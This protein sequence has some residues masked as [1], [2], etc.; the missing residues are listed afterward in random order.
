[1]MN[2]KG[3]T[4]TWTEPGNTTPL[5]SN[6]NKQIMSA[7]DRDNVLGD[8]DLGSYLNKI[9]DPNYVDPA[10]TKRVGNN[11]LDKDSFL[12]LFLA[13]L[14]NQDPMSPLESHE[15][16]AQLAQF[17]S[18]EK[19]GAID[20]GIKDL[21][22]A[23]N[24]AKSFDS[25]AMIGRHIEGDSSKI[26][27]TDTKEAHDIRFNL[28]GDAVKATL[29]VKN[30]QGAEIRKMEVSG[31]KKGD[32][33]V[34]WDGNLENGAPAPVGDYTVAISANSSSGQKI[35]AETAFRGQVTGV[36]FTAEGPV[37]MMGKTTVR[38]SDVKQISDPSLA[39]LQDK[40]VNQAVKVRDLKSE[41]G[42][43]PAIV[44]GIG[45][46]LEN[47]GMSSGLIEKIGNEVNAKEET[48]E[49]LK[50][51]KEVTP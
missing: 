23:Q 38:M 46:N 47:V 13:Q 30:A 24:P 42:D 6:D 20:E 29:S 32:N 41:H 22:R 26:I 31:L 17:T 2:I 3:G 34:S 4:K 43:N 14:K 15:L 27:R 25:L 44:A 21:S 50:N 51:G 28:M 48:Q 9:A 36:N 10:K 37:L 33:K 39:Q 19:L 1:M 16:A 35:F 11:Q 5:R 12:K 45:G 40:N 49:K 18:I 7:N 8:Q